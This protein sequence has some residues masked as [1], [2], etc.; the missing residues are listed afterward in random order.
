MA[1]LLAPAGSFDSLRAAVNAGA[2]AVYIGGSLFGAR[3]YADNPDE[4][5]L[6]EGIRYCHLHGRKIYL[7]VNT[8]L[9]EKEINEMLYPYLLPYYENGVDGLIVQDFGVV[10]YVREHFPGLDLHASTQMTVTGSDGARLLKKA[11]ISRVVPARELSLAEIRRIIDETGIE[12][13]TFIHGAMCYSYSGQCLFSSLLG[14]RSGNRGRCAQPCRLP[15]SVIAAEDSRKKKSEGRTSCLLSMKDMCTLDLLPEIV[16]AGIASLKIEGRMKRPEYTAG[17]VSVYRKY[18][19]LYEETGKNGFRVEEED[20]RILLD[21]YNR[22]GFSEGYYHQH[23]GK[24]MMAM[25]RPNHSGTE[26]AVVRSVGRGKGRAAALERLG[27]KDVLE[28]VPGT[29][30]TLSEDVKQGQEFMFPV[31]GARLREG[32][33]LRRT[34]NESLNR[35]L[36]EKYIEGNCKEKIKG[37][38]MI[39][40]EGTAILK[41]NHPTASV[42]VEENIAQPALNQPTSADAIRKQLQKTGNTPFLFTSLDIRTEGNLFIP[43][44]SLNELRRKGL[45][46]LEQEILS[47]CRQRTGMEW[48]QE[49]AHFVSEQTPDA[50]CREKETSGQEDS[51]VLSSKDYRMN[52]LVTSGDQLEAVLASGLSVLDTVYFDFMLLDNER[53]MEQMEAVREK[54]WNC[55]MNLPPVLRQKDR[56]FLERKTVRSCMKRMDGFLLHTIDELA[57]L[58]EFLKNEEKTAVLVADENFYTYNKRAASFLREQG[59]DRMTLPAELNFGELRGLATADG[60]LTVYGYQ[61]LMQSAQC[62]I[63]NTKG[64]TKKPETIRIRD[65]KNAEFPVLNRCPVCCNT[66]YNS[67]P[68]ELAGC[69]AEI[70]K[71]ALRYVRL[72]FTVETKEETSRILEKYE[73]SLFD[74]DDTYEPVQEGT[75]GHFRRGVE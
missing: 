7:T 55:Y 59:I 54:G 38:L 42:S 14:G 66:I 22:G 1:E 6:I 28:L 58:Q 53:V 41:L 45:E 61:P 12:V 51:A 39:S 19:D 74:C 29:E 27:K 37:E 62:V 9:K 3:A 56:D 52:V 8:L 49:K 64:C 17:V 34:R 13:E 23:N 36:Q 63:K 30:I 72:S 40:A 43:V 47:G 60:E 68:L 71:L 5:Q 26:A 20:R 65:R 70:G 67:V 75:R 11:G 73:K 2:D 21:L 18:L 35:M 48:R 57:C 44:K 15:Y 46:A 33:I 4:E 10:K 69:R 31:S 24:T 50:G 25:D 32:M 16:D